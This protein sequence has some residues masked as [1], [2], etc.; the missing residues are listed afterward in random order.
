DSESIFQPQW[1]PDGMLYFVSDRSGWWNLYRCDPRG[2]GAAH[3]L[4]PRAA[5]FGQAQW[6]FG[7][8]TY[9]FLSADQLVCAYSEAGQDRLARLDIAAQRLTPLDLPYSDFGQVRTF[10]NRI[11]RRAGSP[12]DPSAVVL[13]DPANGMVEMLR[14][15]AKLVA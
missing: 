1:S 12:A 4:C 7:Q 6:N 3:P 2:D 11:V 14:P 5:E 15:S 10:G 13:V 8:S 9:A